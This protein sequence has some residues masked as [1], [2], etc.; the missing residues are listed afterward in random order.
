MF[1]EK[2]VIRPNVVISDENQRRKSSQFSKRRKT[3][4]YLKI[5][6]HGVTM[7]PEVWYAETMNTKRLLSLSVL[8][9]AAGWAPDG[10]L[11]SSI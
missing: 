1:V 8:V 7:E 4:S 3:L 10:S 5:D 2:I 6:G 9:I 11:R